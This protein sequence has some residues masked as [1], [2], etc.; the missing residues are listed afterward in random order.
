MRENVLTLG[1]LLQFAILWCCCPTALAGPLD[2]GVFVVETG[3]AGATA[4]G[5]DVLLFVNGKFISTFCHKY[6][7]FRE[8]TYSIRT[9]DGGL[10]FSVDSISEN[11]G[12]MHWEGIVRDTQIEVSYVW[13]DRPRWYWP[14]SSVKQGWARSLAHWEQPDPTTAGDSATP[15]QQLD[16]R[17]F[18]VQ[19]GLQGKPPDHEDYLN[20]WNGKFVSSGCV[21]SGF[22]PSAYSVS[23]QEDGLHFHAET[24]SSEYGVMIWD[25]V[26]RG[27]RIDTTARWMYKRW[28]WE[29]DRNYRYQ[30]AVALLH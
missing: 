9:V 19:S 22:Q 14:W 17:V 8:G 1:L 2:G 11:R 25:G 6:H 13:N 12:T 28:Y 7:G 3:E 29:I 26:I 20:F 23:E 5:R 10:F 4:S 15:S 18:Y 30:G 16:G 21:E 24:I 27:N